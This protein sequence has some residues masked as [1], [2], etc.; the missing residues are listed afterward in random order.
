MSACPYT[1]RNSAETMP[2]AL[3]IA[4]NSGRSNIAWRV[5]GRGRDKGY[6]SSR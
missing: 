3:E 5:S 2:A 4:S 6:D 1:P